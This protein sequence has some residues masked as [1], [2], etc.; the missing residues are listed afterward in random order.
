M[1]SAVIL[2]SVSDLGAGQRLFRRVSAG[3]ETPRQGG[4][5]MGPITPNPSRDGILVRFALPRE[6]EVTLVVYDVA[7]RRLAELAHGRLSAGEHLVPW[8]FRD[9]SGAQ[10]SPGYFLVKL[11]A[12]DQVLTRRGIRMR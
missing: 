5:W 8:D 7:G 4:L 11:R 6:E 12:G 9:A 1:L 10:L 2:K 3:G